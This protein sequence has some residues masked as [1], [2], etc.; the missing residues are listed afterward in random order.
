M[1]RTDIIL[2]KVIGSKAF[3]FD[4]DTRVDINDFMW[5]AGLYE[6][7]GNIYL[8]PKK[9]Q[10]QISICSTDRDAIEKVLRIIQKGTIQG[11][12][13]KN[14]LNRKPFY[15]WAVNTSKGV[16]IIANALFPYLCDRRREQVIA[17]LYKWNNRSD[18]RRREQREAI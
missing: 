6:G 1:K 2:G 14:V 9:K 5:F 7:G 17:A 13:N 18:E 3:G 10:L 15:Y 11:P 16:E 4:I 12:Y 8:N